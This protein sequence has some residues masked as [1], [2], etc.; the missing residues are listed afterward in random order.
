MKFS[1]KT[2]AFSASA[3]ALSAL[4]GITPAGAQATRTWVSGTGDDAN[5]CSRTAPCKTFAG[6]ISKTAAGGEINCID[7]AGYGSVTIT[8]AMTL[9]CSNTLGSVLHSGTQGIVVNAGASDNVI[10]NGLE[11]NGAGTTPGTKGISFL[12]GGSL[13]VR[14]SFIYGSR[15]SPAW[16]VSFTPSAASKLFIIDT[17]IANNGTGTTGGGVL[18]QPTGLGSASASLNNVHIVNNANNGLRVDSTG[19]T[20]PGITVSLD[21]VESDGNQQGIVALNPPGTTTIGMM[22]ANSM[23][24]LNGAVGIFANGAAVTIRVGNSTITG[25]ALGVAALGS[26]TIASYGDNR[27]DGNPTVGTANDGAFTGAVIPKK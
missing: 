18:I 6:A 9:N 19:N 2:G 3:L 10:I 8:K 11:L 20:G 12:A 14:D 5:P 4:V 1:F 7:P 24:A 13:I 17:T 16:G 15:T 25:N 23:I 27:L 21:H 26:S 22:V